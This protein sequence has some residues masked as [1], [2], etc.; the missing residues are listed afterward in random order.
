MPLSHCHIKHYGNKRLVD[1]LI[2]NCDSNKKEPALTNRSPVIGKLTNI[3]AIAILGEQVVPGR[4]ANFQ[5]ARDSD[6]QRAPHEL[7]TMQWSSRAA[8][9]QQ[10][11]ALLP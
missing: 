9:W 1:L 11:E 2:H 6:L 5:V 4:S 3:L 7:S 10:V 8:G